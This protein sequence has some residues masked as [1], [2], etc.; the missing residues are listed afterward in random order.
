V[1][2]GRLK[3][4]SLVGAISASSFTPEPV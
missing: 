2:E 3:T 1:Q 4:F